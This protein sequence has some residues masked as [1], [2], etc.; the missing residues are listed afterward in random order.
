M[1]NSLFG[2]GNAMPR[3]APGADPPALSNQ[4]IYY[5]LYRDGYVVL[6]GVVEKRKVDTALRA[7]NSSLGRNVPN[8]QD[9]CPDVANTPAIASLYNETAVKGIMDQLLSES[10]GVTG[11]QIAIRFPGDNTSGTDFKVPQHWERHWH[12]DGLGDNQVNGRQSLFGDIRNFTALVGVVLQDTPDEHMGNL[13][14]YPGSH[15]ELQEHFRS[16]GFHDL[17]S[18]GVQGLPRA[19]FH[20]GHKHITAKAGDVVILNYCLAH[21]VAPNISPHLRY[22]VYFRI[23]SK[24]HRRKPANDTGN[25]E[26]NSVTG[27]AMASMNHYPQAMLHVWDEWPGL[28]HMVPPEALPEVVVEEDE[29]RPSSSGEQSRQSGRSWGWFSR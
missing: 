6:P 20:R 5:T 29:I 12:I 24:M 21:N 27:A 9:M 11:G 23:T 14:V 22:N 17:Y 10:T 18:Q 19:P 13:V 15:F 16:R 8:R 4:E 2:R 26:R 7:I 1:I 28:R 25:N 3:S